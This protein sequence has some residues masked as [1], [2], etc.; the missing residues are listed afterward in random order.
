MKINKITESVL[1]RLLRESQEEKEERG[2][3][4][5]AQAAGLAAC[6]EK[7]GTITQAVIY[8]PR[9][10]M[11]LIEELTDR[12]EVD[13]AVNVAL[14]LVIQGV[15]ELTEPNW[16]CNGARVITASAVKNKGDGGLV[17]GVGFA[18]SPKGILTPD[19]HSVSHSAQRG[20][21]KQTSRGGRPFDDASLPPEKQRTPDDTSDDCRIHKGK[22]GCGTHVP[23]AEPAL[24][25]SYEEEGWEKPL[26]RKLQDAHD[27]TMQTLT[28]AQKDQA[29]YVLFRSFDSF[30]NEHY[31]G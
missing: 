25:R 11:E 22:D 27:K 21:M 6:A 5:M 12:E 26:F 2:R 14:N 3:R 1:R 30:F 9:K 15:V 20:W 7:M 13:E 8:D 19:R 4:R 18:L 23:G 28:Q 31:E 16:P 24:N 10:L 17:Y 29:T